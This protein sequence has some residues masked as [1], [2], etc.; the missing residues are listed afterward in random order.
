[1]L[2]S[3]LLWLWHMNHNALDKYHDD[4]IKCKHFPRYWPFV[5]GIH[6]WPV[7]SPHQGQWRGALM[8]SLICAWINS[9][10]N[11]REA[12]DLRCHRTHY[13]VIIMSLLAITSRDVERSATREFLWYWRVSILTAIALCVIA[14]VLYL[15]WHWSYQNTIATER[16]CNTRQCLMYEKY[17]HY[18]EVESG[19]KDLLSWSNPSYFIL[20][21][22]AYNKEGMGA[23]HGYCFCFLKFCMV[24]PPHSNWYKYL[25]GHHCVCR[26]PST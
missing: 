11:N 22:R 6:R 20:L 12:G 18:S 14:I 4:V 10:V 16:P 1:M 9:W 26:C 3:M 25:L 5:R 21:V 19:V 13:D 24:V 15:Q 8:F 17:F 2:S 23:P 7:N